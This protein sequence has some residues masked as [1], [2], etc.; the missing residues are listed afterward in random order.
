MSRGRR[1]MIQLDDSTSRSMYSNEPTYSQEMEQDEEDDEDAGDIP[2]PERLVTEDMIPDSYRLPGYSIPP[3]PGRE[4]DNKVANF[5]AEIDALE[6]PIIEQQTNVL[7]YAASPHRD[8]SPAPD[9]HSPVRKKVNA[10]SNM[11]VKGTPEFVKSRPDDHKHERHLQK[12]PWPEEPMTDWQQLKDDK[13][14]YPYYWNMTTGEVVWD[15]PPQFSQYLLLHKEYEERVEKGLR[16]GTLDPTYRPLEKAAQDSMSNAEILD[17]SLLK[18]EDK[19][20]RHQKTKSKHSTSSEDSST[21]SSGSDAKSLRENRTRSPKKRERK[22][23]KKEFDKGQQEVTSSSSNNSRDSEKHVKTTVSPDTTRLDDKKPL[24]ST[25]ADDSMDFDIDDIDKQLELALEKKRQELMKAEEEKEKKEDNKDVEKD[26]QLRDRDRDKNHD[27]DEDRHRKH[28]RHDKERDRRRERE[29]EHEEKKPK[30]TLKERLRIE[31]ELKLEKERRKKKAIEDLMSRE[32]E[33]TVGSR[34]GHKRHSEEREGSRDLKRYRHD[35]KYPPGRDRGYGELHR[36]DYD[37]WVRRGDRYAPYDYRFEDEPLYKPP[38]PTEEML[39][40]KEEKRSQVVDYGHGRS[41][42]YDLNGDSDPDVPRSADAREI[43]V[44]KLEALQLAELALSKLE[45]LE[46]TKKGL[47]K[48]QILLI[49]LETRHADWQ[50]GGLTTNHFL[51]K[52]R[53]A[54]WQLEQYEGSAAPA[55]WKCSW[56][57][58][59]RRYFYTHKRTGKT[60]WDYPDADDMKAEDEKASK[61]TIHKTDARPVPSVSSVFTTR[62]ELISS[63]TAPPPPPPTEEHPTVR[64]L[65]L[66]Y[67]SESE[68]EEEADT[69][70]TPVHARPDRMV[71]ES[72]TQVSILHGEL[73]PL[74]PGDHPS[75]RSK[76]EKKK[77]K[78][79]EKSKKRDKHESEGLVQGPVVGPLG[80][81]TSVGPS[82]PPGQPPPPGVEPSTFLDS[83]VSLHQVP[84]Y[85]SADEYAMNE[86]PLEFGTV[87]SSGPQLSTPDTGSMVQASHGPEYYP[88]VTSSD[89]F[90]GAGDHDE[91]SVGT[92]PGTEEKKKRK[93]E[94]MGSGSLSLKKK[95]VSSM[96]QKWQKVKKEVELEEQTRQMR[97]AEIRRKLAELE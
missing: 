6:E 13:T 37:S 66:M 50:A 79:K 36:D 61:A 31:M 95:H 94:K 62:E 88:T 71:P 21:D 93:K 63:V 58:D 5:L 81:M 47:S 30:L 27:R 7:T 1:H 52:L 11:F 2:T 77:K 48:L 60:Q 85:M 57:R 46:V 19:D 54:N 10:Y 70:P 59:Y 8:S 3:P 91:A 73:P 12:E 33:H 86:R 92:A 32:L 67:A 55:G 83:S 23:P 45:F 16:E 90:G 44:K 76:R 18:S 34:R 49:E 29:S 26:S 75:D 72:H 14:N 69:V 41:R 4:M 35:D 43:E 20:S 38:P 28:D 9:G 42:Q 22:S 24:E 17:Q 64:S 82:L 65:Q 68:E 96:V 78:K 53:E 51:G 84:V 25:E 40:Y 74:P 39:A 97:E 56:D 89:D 80:S 15:M 87:I